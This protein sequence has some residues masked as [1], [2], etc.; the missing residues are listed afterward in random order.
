[1]T[2]KLKSNDGIENKRR[3][4]FSTQMITTPFEN[5][6]SLR[7]LRALQNKTSAN[8]RY[9]QWRITLRRKSVS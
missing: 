2:V 4:L 3:H 9:R 6:A 7:I 8:I 5:T 1:M